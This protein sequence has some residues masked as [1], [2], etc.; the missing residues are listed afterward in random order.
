MCIWQSWDWLHGESW[1][2]LTGSVGF[3]K[4]QACSSRPQEIILRRQEK[5]RS[6]ELIPLTSSAFGVAGVWVGRAQNWTP[7]E[8]S[9]S[10]C[11]KRDKN[12]H[13]LTFALISWQVD[14]R[15]VASL[16]TPVPQWE[17]WLEHCRTL[18]GLSECTQHAYVLSHQAVDCWETLLVTQ[19][20][21]P[22]KQ[23]Y[24]FEY[25]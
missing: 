12:P 25:K 17:H 23:E 1:C 15:Q 7:G 11:E 22:F 9:C 20:L 18:S 4:D 6:G 19:G 10:S 21:L 13:V 16:P 5:K 3:G 8:V 2:S 14:I 24:P